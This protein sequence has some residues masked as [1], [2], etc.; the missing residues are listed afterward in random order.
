[1]TCVVRNVGRF[2]T[3]ARIPSGRKAARAVHVGGLH[4]QELDRVSLRCGFVLMRKWLQLK[5]F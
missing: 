1:M 3:R 4:E 2:C 5:P